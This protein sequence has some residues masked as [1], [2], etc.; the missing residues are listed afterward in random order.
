LNNI[1]QTTSLSNIL[2][3]TGVVDYDQVN[4]PIRPSEA[5]PKIPCDSLPE[6][7]YLL[8]REDVYRYKK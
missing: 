8:W 1:R 3:K 2:C 5:N 6:I 4:A 7:N